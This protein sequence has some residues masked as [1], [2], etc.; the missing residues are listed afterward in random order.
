MNFN[1]SSHRMNEKGNENKTDKS[2]MQQSSP[3]GISSSSIA[4][5]FRQKSM[6]VVISPEVSAKTTPMN[7]IIEVDS[8]PNT[9]EG[10]VEYPIRIDLDKSIT[11]HETTFA[12]HGSK[13]E[14]GAPNQTSNPFSFFGQSKVLPDTSN[15][16]SASPTFLSN[17][18]AF[19][20]F[21]KSSEI[22]RAHV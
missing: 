17:D 5:F 11:S 19:K 14:N 10:K 22:G 20:F 8:S 12:T 2:S 7:D 16:R 18:S 6:A 13:F 4:N 3:G 9:R 21:R 15:K 1:N